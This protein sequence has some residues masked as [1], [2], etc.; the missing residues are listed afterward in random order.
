MEFF[1]QSVLPQ[2]AQH[3][4]LLKY[5]LVLAYMI[6]LPYFS[7]L[8]GSMFISMNLSKKGGDNSELNAIAYRVIEFLT[9]NRLASIALGF[10]P[11]FSI[12]FIYMQ[13]LQLSEI[14]FLPYFIISFGFMLIGTISVYFYKHYFSLDLLLSENSIEFEKSSVPKSILDSLS[15][16]SSNYSKY[17]K[18]SVWLLSLGIYFFIALSSFFNHD[19]ISEFAFINVLLSWASIIGFLQFIVLSFLFSYILLGYNLFKSKVSESMNDFVSIILKKGMVLSLLMPLLLLLDSITTSSSAVSENFFFYTILCLFLLLL[20][21]TSFYRSLKFGQVNKFNS[22]IFL[23]FLFIAVYVIRG[24]YLFDTSSQLEV[25]KLV[26]NYTVYENKIQSG[27]GGN[28]L[29]VSGADIFNG[30]CIACHNF[31]KKIVGPAYKDVLQKY[32]GK[33]VNLVKFVLNPI[34]VNPDYPVMPNQGLKPNEAE[35][36]ADY[37]M[38]T[39]T[40]Q[41]K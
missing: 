15:S 14:S 20:I 5:M 12:V 22:L 6:F 32:E 23:A 11:M 31:D 41:Y 28:I 8:L 19:S 2:S 1:Q 33:M 30:K 29:V 13:L 39:Y 35:A 38:K 26:E 4:I 9:F 25:N 36:I 34:K 27:L 10:V 7:L 24:Q 21:S 18:Y 40:E 16:F 3:I 17:G 37:I